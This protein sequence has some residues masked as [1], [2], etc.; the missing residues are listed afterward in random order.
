MSNE[1]HAKLWQFG[2]VV[3]AVSGPDGECVQREIR[4]YA[5]QYEQDGPVRVELIPPRRRS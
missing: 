1:W 4:H 5:A 3:A 2:M